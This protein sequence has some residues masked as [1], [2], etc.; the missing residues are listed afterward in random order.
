MDDEGPSERH[1]NST[2]LRRSWRGVYANFANVSHSDYEFTVTFARV[3]HEVE[4]AEVPGVVVARVSS[5]H[6]SWRS[7]STR[8]A[9]AAPSGRPRRASATARGRRPVGPVGPCAS[10]C[11]GRRRCRVERRAEGR[12]HLGHPRELPRSRRCS[13]RSTPRARTSCGAWATLSA[14]APEPNRCCELVPERAVDLPG[15]QPRPRGD[16]RA[17]RSTTSTATRA[18]AVELDERRARRGRARATWRRCARGERH[19]VELFHGSPLDPV[20]DYVLE[21]AGGRVSLERQRSAARAWSATATSPSSSPTPA[22]RS[23]AA[24]RRGDTRSTS[25]RRASCS[26]RARSASRAAATRGRHGC[27][28]TSRRARPTFRR[29]DYAGRGRTQAEIRAAGLPRDARRPP[30]ATAVSVARRA[31]RPPRSAAARRRGSRRARA[32][33]APPRAP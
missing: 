17:S 31:R 30:G 18:A 32:R 25:P 7:S 15:R 23:P 29:I 12:G 6:G 20:W 14:T 11:D 33:A 3:D 10:P 22:A 1:L 27:S 26:T 8:W 28:S 21:R 24:S 19:G 2:S 4:D 9:T 16:R 13:P 5:R